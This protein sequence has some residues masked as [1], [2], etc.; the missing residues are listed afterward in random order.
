MRQLKTILYILLF[1]SNSFAQDNP[2]VPQTKSTDL[3]YAQDSISRSNQPQRLYS[4]SQKEVN[5]FV[6]M[7][8]KTAHVFGRSL[9]TCAGLNVFGTPINF[10]K[11]KKESSLAI[12]VFDQFQEEHPEASEET[13]LKVRKRIRGKRNKTRIGGSVV[14]SV[15]SVHLIAFVSIF[16]F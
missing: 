3:W 11:S 9:L 8:Y 4:I 2:W 15:I 16:K 14:G 6:A 13:L 10:V 12:E 1:A 5:E 7:N